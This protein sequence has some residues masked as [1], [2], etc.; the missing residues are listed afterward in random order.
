MASKNQIFGIFVLSLIL[1]AGCKQEPEKPLEP[2][3]TEPVSEN[4]DENQD[5]TFSTMSFI[6]LSYNPPEY[7]FDQPKFNNPEY[8]LPLE[9]LPENYQRDLVEKFGKELSKEQLEIFLE[10]GVIILPGDSERFEIAYQQLS[11]TKYKNEDREGVPIF[12]TTDSVMHLFHIE[13][14]ELL[15]N[16]E[17]NSLIPMLDEFLTKTLQKSETQYST[18]D[19][20]NLK[21]LARRNLAYLSVAKK[22]LDPDF[23]VPRIV[24]EEV[25]LELERIGDHNGFYQSPLFSK[26]C[27]EICEKILYPSEYEEGN[28]DKCSQVVKINV[29]YQGK[30][31][32]FVDLYKE[33]C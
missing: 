15:K 29:T 14:N 21:E 23:S 5:L 12:I 26:D 30:E 10:N 17:L 13:F 20:T 18:L 33:V 2:I 24:R 9:E 4:T 22:L 31:W 25:N 16:I 7:S 1:I 6:Q 11:E 19:D 3:S 8:D 28:G 27:P 32:E